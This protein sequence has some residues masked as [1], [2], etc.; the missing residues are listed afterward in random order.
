MPAWVRADTEKHLD[1][2]A[3][4]ARGADVRIELM[5]GEVWR[6]REREREAVR[7]AWRRIGEVIGA[8]I[9]V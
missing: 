5:K 7:M 6:C 8:D 2:G 1:D 3:M 4:I 9:V